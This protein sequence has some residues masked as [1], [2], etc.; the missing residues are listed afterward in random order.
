MSSYYTEELNAN[1]MP[2]EDIL[3]PCYPTLLQ[4][5]LCTVQELPAFFI[6]LLTHTR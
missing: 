5:G 2:L 4:A 1:N 3:M 6:K